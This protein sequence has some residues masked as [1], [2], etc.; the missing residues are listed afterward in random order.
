MSALVWQAGSNNFFFQRKTFVFLKSRVASC[1]LSSPLPLFFLLLAP[2][3]PFFLL[4]PTS[5]LSNAHRRSNRVFLA[6]GYSPLEFSWNMC[7]TFYLAVAKDPDVI[8]G[9][10]QF[11]RVKEQ[12]R[13]VIIR[14]YG[15]FGLEIHM[16]GKFKKKGDVKKNGKDDRERKEDWL[17]GKVTR[18]RYTSGPQV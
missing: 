15:H 8:T 1:F 4:L 5:L 13:P 17:E 7:T 18:M 14:F 6:L 12:G 10:S 16:S 9:R 3:L 11:F 2:S